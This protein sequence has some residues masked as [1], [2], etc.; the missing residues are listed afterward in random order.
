MEQ[1]AN[2]E[3]TSAQ[4]VEEEK[5]QIEKNIHEQAIKTWEFIFFDKFLGF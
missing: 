1:I 2:C 3:F 4:S 5:N